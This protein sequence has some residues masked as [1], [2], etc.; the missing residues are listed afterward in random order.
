MKYNPV[1]WFEIYVEDM[2]R[3]KAFY[4]ELVAAKL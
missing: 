4:E 2:K 1:V 3:A